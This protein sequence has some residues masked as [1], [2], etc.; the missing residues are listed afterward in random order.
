MKAFTIFLLLIAAKVPSAKSF[1]DS[2]KEKEV[3]LIHCF[4][5]FLNTLDDLPFAN[6][7]KKIYLLDDAEQKFCGNELQRIKQK[8]FKEKSD[9]QEN[10]NRDLEE[11]G[12]AKCVL[13]SLKMMK[14]FQSLVKKMLFNP[15]VLHDPQY[16]Q[17]SMENRSIA[18]V[19]AIQEICQKM[20]TAQMFCNPDKVFSKAFDEFFV[21]VEERKFFSP[22]EGAEDDRKDADE[23][24]TDFC[25]LKNTRKNYVSKYFF[26]NFKENPENIDFSMLNC[27]QDFIQDAM[28]LE[29]MLLKQ[30]MESLQNLSRGQENCI[31]QTVTNNHDYAKH[32]LKA[33]AIGKSR[34]SKQKRSKLRGKFVEFMRCFFTRIEKCLGMKN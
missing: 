11:N 23:L 13:E 19:E 8:I 26:Y 31:R 16:I 2:T 24:K 7:I 28:D 10:F 22:I 5:D 17:I 18:Y 20:I 6:E 3:S 27:Q 15:I 33:E 25:L 32:L 12:N 34:F 21:P 29:V 14:V 4:V 1:D 9:F 30:L